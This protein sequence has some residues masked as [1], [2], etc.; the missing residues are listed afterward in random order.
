MKKISVCLLLTLFITTSQAQEIRAGSYNLRNENTYDT[1]NLWMQRYKHVAEL[2]T[3][4][5]FDI[6]GVQEALSHQL[7]TLQMALPGFAYYGIGRDDGKD[8]GEHEAI[9][10]KTDKFELLKSGDFWLSATPDVP[11]KS[12]DAP[13]CNRLCTWVKMKV[14]SSGKI[15]FMFNV[16][17]DYEKDYARNESSKL[18][19]KKIPEIA[20]DAPVIMTGDINGG[21]NTSWYKLLEDSQKLHD[22]YVSAKEPY[23]P[24]G[25]FNGFGKEND[26]ELIDH[27]F[28]TKEFTVK[29]WAVLSDTYNKGKYP[30]DHCPI[31]ATLYFN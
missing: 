5:E 16:H 10:Y 21:N 12:W 23:Y 13:C 8:A 4:H 19:L 11:S 20:G 30:S 27:I 9:F 26:G 7:T 22:T 6:F 28:A 3:Y 18:M 24:R 15:F 17:Y 31:L 1:G 25:S 29:N 14:K 2:I